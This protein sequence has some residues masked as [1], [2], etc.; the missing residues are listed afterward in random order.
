M[1]TASTLGSFF[2]ASSTVIR[3]RTMLSDRALS[4]LGRLSVM[5]PTWPRTCANTSPVNFVI[6]VP[7]NPIVH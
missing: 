2:Q 3:S 6:F 5:Q 4:A 7:S 1:A